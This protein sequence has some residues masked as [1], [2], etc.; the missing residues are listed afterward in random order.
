M[1]RRRQM[2]E[3]WH[4]IRKGRWCMHTKVVYH[5]Y[6]PQLDHEDYEEISTLTP[7]MMANGG[8]NKYRSC[9]ECG[10]FEWV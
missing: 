5:G 9:N 6:V 4:R 7:W 2:R 1:N 3:L 8:A 10:R